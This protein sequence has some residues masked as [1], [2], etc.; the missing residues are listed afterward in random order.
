MKVAGQTSGG[1]GIGSGFGVGVGDM[2]NMMNIVKVSILPVR[3]A[4]PCVWI[5]CVGVG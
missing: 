1:I 3:V 2:K 4:S 5:S